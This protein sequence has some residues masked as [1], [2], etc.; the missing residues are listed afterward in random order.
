MGDVLRPS[1]LFQ[2]SLG[3]L[4]VH[5]V[6]TAKKNSSR[7]SIV[8]EDGIRRTLLDG[9]P[10]AVNA[11]KSPSGASGVH[12]QGRTPF[13]VIGEGDVTLP[14]PLPRTEVANPTP[15]SP[16][17]SSVL[18]VHFSAKVEKNTTGVALSLEDQ[19]ELSEVRVIDPQTGANVALIQGLASAID[20]VPLTLDGKAAGFL[21]LEYSL[22]HLAV[23]PGDCRS[24][25][26]S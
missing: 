11:A 22:A 8:D 7:I 17:F 13:V 15:A 4:L 6:G 25:T 26:H 20:V 18:A 14:G 3:N 9:L 1:T 23:G 21:T 12:L 24:S 2:T 5:E 10:S 16:I 19:F